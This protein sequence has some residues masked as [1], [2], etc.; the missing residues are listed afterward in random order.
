VFVRRED[1]AAVLVAANAG[2]TDG[3]HANG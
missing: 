1:A 2:V 3:E